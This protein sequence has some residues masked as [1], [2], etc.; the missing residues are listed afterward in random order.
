MKVDNYTYDGMASVRCNKCHILHTV[1]F[2]G[3]DDIFPEEAIDEALVELGWDV[4]KGICPDCRDP[5]EVRKEFDEDSVEDEP[6]DE[7]EDYEIMLGDD[8]E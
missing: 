7:Y 4:C 2:D 1:S 6:Y 3:A 5:E 8:D